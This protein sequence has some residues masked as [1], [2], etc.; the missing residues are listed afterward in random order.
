MVQEVP[1]EG[2]ISFDPNEELPQIRENFSELI[3]RAIIT[4]TIRWVIG[5]AI[6][7]AVTAMT[8]RFDWLWVAGIVVAGVSLMFTLA[9]HVIIQRKFASITAKAAELETELGD[10]RG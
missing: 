7:W 4:W 6:I 8:G 10:D 2:G 1:P 5:F 9:T 3:K